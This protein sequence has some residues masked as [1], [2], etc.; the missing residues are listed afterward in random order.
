MKFFLLTLPFLVFGFAAQASEG[1]HSHA[2][3]YVGQES[4]TI[5]SLSP[6]DIAELKR[7]GGWGLAKAAELNGVPGPAHLLEMKDEIAL[8]DAQVS[9]IT[10]IYEQMKAQAIEEGERLIILEQELESYFQNGTITDAILRSSLDEIAAARK[11]L[12]YVHLS[13]HLQTPEILS[14]AQIKKYNALRGYSDPDP[15][16][17][18][19]EGHDAEMWRKHNGCQ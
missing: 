10:E 13:T 14:P 11:K 5:K 19:P 7:G 4:R 9:A 18:I 1:Q 6:D 15:C 3:K 16:A 2:S 17:N 8:D 12:R